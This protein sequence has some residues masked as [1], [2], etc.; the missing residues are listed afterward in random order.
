VLEAR[1]GSSTTNYRNKS[2]FGT[3]HE[4]EVRREKVRRARFK[5]ISDFFYLFETLQPP[6]MW[7]ELHE[8][9]A[10]VNALEALNRKTAKEVEADRVAALE[11]EM[12]RL[13]QRVVALGELNKKTTEEI[14]AR[15]HEQMYRNQ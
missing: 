10:R 11:R 3:T 9:K 6:T 5:V 2:P 14:K 15:Q 7:D 8:L 12:E 13:E 1:R 4:N